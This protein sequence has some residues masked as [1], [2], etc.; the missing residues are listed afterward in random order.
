MAEVVAQGWPDLQVASVRDLFLLQGIVLQDEAKTVRVVGK[1]RAA[2]AHGALTFSVE[3]VGA[4]HPQRIHYRAVV[5]LVQRLPD[6][7]PFE[8]LSL[9][10]GYT[11][12]M[13]LSEIY[14]QWLFHGPLFQGIHQVNHMGIDGVVAVLASSSPQGWISDASQERWLIDPLMLDSG[15]QLLILWSREHWNMTTL[16]SR[17]RAYRRFG[18][19]PSKHV[20]CEVRI[21]PNAD[22]QTIHA[23]IVFVNTDGRVMGILE[24]IEGSCTRALNRLV[25]RDSLARPSTRVSKN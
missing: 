25:G 2:A 15:L 1:S 4:E 3:I 16:P 13:D 22:G 7:P 23:D 8:P 12:S 24:D 18:T 17:F 6:P 20:H 21:R 11:L 19:Q 10:K 14:R 5:D 9:T